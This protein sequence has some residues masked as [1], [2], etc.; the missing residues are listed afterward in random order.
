L[1][2]RIAFRSGCAAT[3]SSAWQLSEFGQTSEID[4]DVGTTMSALETIMLGFLLSWI[5]G[6][7]LMAYLFWAGRQ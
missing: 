4:H 5:P 6:L 1:G 3:T 7:V 2:K